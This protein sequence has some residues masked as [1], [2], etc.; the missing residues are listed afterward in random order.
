MRKVNVINRVCTL[1]VPSGPRPLS[2]CLIFCPESGI[3]SLKLVSLLFSIVI[4]LQLR[5]GFLGR[6]QISW[7]LLWLDVAMWCS[8]CQWRGRSYPLTDLRGSLWSW[9][10]TFL[11]STFVW[12]GIARV[13][14]EATQQR[15]QSHCE[16]KSLADWSKTAHCQSL[17]LNPLHKREVI[18]LLS[19]WVWIFFVAAS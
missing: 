19:H 1:K 16:P 15:L 18:C 5:C 4:E 2:S 13:T 12:M 7:S 8:A 6:C 17:H 10:S 14:L 9:P 11:P 3:C